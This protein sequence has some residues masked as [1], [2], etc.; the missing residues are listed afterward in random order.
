MTPAAVSRRR[1]L[2][3]IAR[4]MLSRADS[5]EL[6]LCGLRVQLTRLR[7]G[8]HDPDNPVIKVFGEDVVDALGA[9]VIDVVGQPA[10]TDQWLLRIR[11]GK[12]WRALP[13]CGRWRDDLLDFGTI[14]V[15]VQAVREMGQPRIFGLPQGAD[16]AF[17]PRPRRPRQVFRRM[18]GDA[19]AR[20]R[21]TANPINRSTIG[22]N[23]KQ[24]LR[25]AVR[26]PR[27]V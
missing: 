11:V 17:A 26:L 3:L 19:G 16:Q 2:I 14:C 6:Q 20:I 23:A 27:S 21:E 8:K 9:C 5:A 22:E 12:H 10:P 18:A 13:P 15:S 1:E 7:F 24:G 25:G 4:A